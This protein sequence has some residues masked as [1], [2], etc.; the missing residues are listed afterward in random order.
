MEQKTIK[1][2]ISSVSSEVPGIGRAKRP[3]ASHRGIP[4][5]TR[6]ASP[7]WVRS[8]HP[9]GPTKQCRGFR[10]TQQ[11]LSCQKWSRGGRIQD[12]ALHE[13]I[14]SLSFK[15]IDSTVTWLHRSLRVEQSNLNRLKLRMR[16]LRHLRLSV[17]IHAPAWGATR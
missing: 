14:L 7:R 15:Q 17:S 4:V 8:G 1:S 9:T 6:D 2:S 13:G 11:L 16:L 5:P 10:F 3:G 12:A